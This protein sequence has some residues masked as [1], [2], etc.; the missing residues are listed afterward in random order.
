M[1]GRAFASPARALRGVL[2]GL[3]CTRRVLS[4][5]RIE[6]LPHWIADLA[7]LKELWLQDNPITVLPRQLEQC[8]HLRRLTVDQPLQKDAKQVL[9]L[10]KNNREVRYF[11]KYGTEMPP[12]KSIDPDGREADDNGGASG[13]LNT[14]V[15]GKV[16]QVCVVQ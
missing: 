3:L 6:N 1:C 13:G 11:Q 16:T 8:L 12:E 9:L 2:T 7:S 5:N 14:S 15:I 10:C 4:C